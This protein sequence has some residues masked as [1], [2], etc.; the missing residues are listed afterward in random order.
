VKLRPP[1]Q[2]AQ[3]ADAY[4]FVAGIIG[5]GARGMAELAGEILV[6]EQVTQGELLRI[7]AILPGLPAR[8]G[9]PSPPAVSPSGLSHRPPTAMSRLSRSEKEFVSGFGD[10]PAD[11]GGSPGAPARTPGS[12]MQELDARGISPPLPVLRTHRALR[13]MQV[14]QVLRVLTTQPQSMAEF[15]SLV[16]HVPQYELVS[17]EEKNGEFV[18]LLRKRR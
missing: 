9:S 16:K 3:V 12:T 5:Q 11:G 17:Q 2:V 15:Q 6:D 13:A 8:I 14:G 4:D 7:P 1:L 18:H 10:L